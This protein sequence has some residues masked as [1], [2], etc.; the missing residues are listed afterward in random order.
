V[1]AGRLPGCR[2][3]EHYERSFCREISER[4]RV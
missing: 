1:N 2:D 3:K 4:E